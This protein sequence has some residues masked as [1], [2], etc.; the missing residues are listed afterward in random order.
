[1]QEVDVF[2]VADPE[3]KRDRTALGLLG[4]LAGD[5]AIFEPFRNAVQPKQVRSCIQKFYQ[6]QANEERKANRDN[7]PIAEDAVITGWILT[8]TA[9]AALLDYFGAKEDTNLGVKGVYFCPGGYKTAIVAIHQLPRTP[10]TLWLRILGK[11]RVQQQAVNELRDLPEDNPFRLAALELLYNLRTIL[12]ARQDLEPEDRELIMELSPLYL[13][14]LEDATQ[15]GI[16]QG[17]QQG[18]QQGQRLM[19]ESMLQVKFGQVDPELAQIIDALIELPPLERT[20][21]IMELDREQLL[22]RLSDNS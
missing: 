7:T 19:V 16:Q 20:Q 9:S 5:R 10:E 22:A 8:P 15:Q 1:M 17:L 3:A 6:I 21:L 13:Q 2:F 11:G 14:R 12:E 4:I 18:N